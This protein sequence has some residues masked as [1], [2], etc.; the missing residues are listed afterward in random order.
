MC[1]TMTC[2]DY[3]G[4]PSESNYLFLGDYIDR[5]NQSLETVSFLPIRSSIQKIFLLTGNHEYASIN[6]IYGF[7]DECKYITIDIEYL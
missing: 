7:Y 6:K 3:Y 4:F 2:C 5:G 1:N